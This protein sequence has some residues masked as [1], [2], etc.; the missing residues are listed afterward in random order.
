MTHTKEPCCD[1]AYK[2]RLYDILVKDLYEKEL[3]KYPTPFLNEYDSL[4]AKADMHDQLVMALGEVCNV[5][6]HNGK[7]ICDEE[8]AA[9]NLITTAKEI[10]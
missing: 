6:K 5:L 1:N 9:L 4:K 8:I 7:L 3:H 10:T 2:A